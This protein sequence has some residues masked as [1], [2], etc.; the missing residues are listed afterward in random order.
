MFTFNLL[1]QQIIYLSI[2]IIIGLK[3]SRYTSEKE[4]ERED[5]ID[6]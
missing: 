2:H 4:R 1:N 6:G 3:L 5:W